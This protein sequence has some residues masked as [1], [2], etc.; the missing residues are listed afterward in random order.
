[1]QLEE[2]GY[3]E[4]DN[5]PVHICSGA[6]RRS[7]WSRYLPKQSTMQVLWR[8]IRCRRSDNASFPI[9]AACS[10]KTMTPATVFASSSC[11]LG[12]SCPAIVDVSTFTTVETLD[13]RSSGS[14]VEY[15]FELE[16][17]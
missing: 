4:D 2:G 11:D 14:D 17:L 8:W 12:E 9:A 13:K 10:G 5:I 3:E 6:A 7:F 16:P 15:R 1:M